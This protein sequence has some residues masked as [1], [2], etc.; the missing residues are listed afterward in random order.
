MKTKIRPLFCEDKRKW[1]PIEEAP[2]LFLKIFLKK[3][4]KTI[5]KPRKM[6][7][8]IMENKAELSALTYLQGQSG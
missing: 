4:K 3:C 8:N 5:D 7:Y 1:E 2:N 6:V